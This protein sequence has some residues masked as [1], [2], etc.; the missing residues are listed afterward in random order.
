MPTDTM[1]M[2]WRAVSG[3]VLRLLYSGSLFWR[4]SRL[5][6]VTRIEVRFRRQQHPQS[7]QEAVCVAFDWRLE[8]NLAV[9]N[10]RFVVGDFLRS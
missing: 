5:N 6:A 3:E 2:T 9:A 4:F 7:P 1:G 10:G 8:A